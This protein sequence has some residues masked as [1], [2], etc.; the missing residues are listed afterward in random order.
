[1]KNQETSAIQLIEEREETSE[2][3]EIQEINALEKDIIK[4]L[5]K[6]IDKTTGDGSSEPKKL[7]FF[8][9]INLK[10]KIFMLKR[11]INKK[12]E[13]L[14]IKKIVRLSNDNA[15]NNLNEEQLKIT[16]NIF[17]S[18]LAEQTYAI[19]KMKEKL[20]QQTIIVFGE[21]NKAND[22]LNLL[23]SI[24]KINETNLFLIKKWTLNFMMISFLNKNLTNQAIVS[25]FLE[26]GGKNINDFVAKK[27]N[28]NNHKDD[29]Q[30]LKDLGF[31]LKLIQGENNY[32]PSP[33]AFTIVGYFTKWE[34]WNDEF[35]LESIKIMLIEKN[36]L[37]DKDSTSNSKIDNHFSDLER[38]Q[39]IF[40]NKNK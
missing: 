1:M 17:N 5:N 18:L 15:L 26:S 11:K 2:I 36:P 12:M 25:L 6:S 16:H 32:V 3:Q 34:K 38:Y 28:P 29:I 23:E 13:Q 9:K 31:T 33:L 21:N 30:I 8:S 7:Y 35:I 37:I 40:Q 24:A 14:K 20:I 27:L 10:L 22:F 39:L 4:L 19:F